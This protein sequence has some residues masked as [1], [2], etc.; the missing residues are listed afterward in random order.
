[1]L[2]IMRWTRPETL[3]DVRELSKSKKG[4]TWADVKAMK[5]TMHYCVGT[6]DHGLTLRPNA[7]QDGSKDFEFT[8]SGRTD[9]NYATYPETRRSVSGYSTFL[10]GSPITVNSRMQITTTLLVTEAEGASCVQCAQDMLY[11]MHILELMELKVAKPMILEC[12]NI[13]CVDLANN[14]TVGGCIK[15]E[16]VYWN[17]LCELK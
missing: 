8:I 9:S 16:A 4:A 7:K 2:H 14:W 10:N 17:F 5:C 11:D 15:H 3:N 1:M 6:P 13:R 12:G